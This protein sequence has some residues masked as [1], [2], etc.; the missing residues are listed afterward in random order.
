MSDQYAA[1]KVRLKVRFEDYG[2]ELPMPL[3]PLSGKGAEAFG[4]G[5]VV[6][7]T[8]SAYTETQDIIPKSWRVELNSPRKADTATVVFDLDQLEIEPQA[9]R[10]A[11]IQIFAGVISSAD[12]ARS[13][14]APGQ[15][16]YLLPDAVPPGYVGAGMSWEIFRGFVDTWTIDYDSHELEVRCRDSTSFFID[17]RIPENAMRNVTR[18]STI[19]EAI[20]AIIAG[21]PGA[22]G[23]VVV[24]EVSRPLPRLGEFLPPSWFDGGGRLTKPKKA[25]AKQPK[26]MSLWDMFE[27]LC[28]SA[29]LK[30]YM[31]APRIAATIAGL[32]AVL[33]AA[34]LVICD[35][36]TYYE[37]QA[38]S[39][40]LRKFR[41]GI[42]CEG[43]RIER[44]LG[45]NPVP[46]IEVRSWDPVAGKQVI[47]RYPKIKVNAKTNRPMPTGKGDRAE[48]DVYTIDTLSGPQAQGQADA[49][50]RS[51]YEQ[52]GRGEFTV[53]LRTH[54]MN[55]IPT[56]VGLETAADM[57]LLRPADTI[58]VASEPQRGDVIV[59][60]AGVHAGS[61]VEDLVQRMVARGFPP[62]FAAKA[63]K[64]AKDPRVQRMF[65][66]QTNIVEFQNDGG[67][68]FNI[69]AISFLDARYEP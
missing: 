16:G 33:P 26:E 20:E 40:G 59:H 43:L 27:D 34:E 63:A 9:I 35:P 46:Y 66:V 56:N 18:G 37:G 61:T 13:N 32:G 8:P 19:K 29:G 22:R 28:V 4:G 10:S 23:T 30:A 60:G 38:G 48:Y 64:A 65:R 31:R 6:E 2:D 53:R 67:Y 1:S 15:A 21:F 39:L 50:A 14:Y 44:Q 47:G 42:N 36:Q 11:T 54:V 5:G 51:F 49:I 68:T 62:R 12:F 58:D 25:K 52:L 69:D 17:A 7:A 55:A 45:G 24:V 57:L 41:Q 3:L